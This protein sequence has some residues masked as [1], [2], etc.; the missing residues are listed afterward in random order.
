MTAWTRALA[1]AALLLAIALVGRGSP[2]RAFDADEDKLIKEAQKDVLELTKA[3][4]SGK[5]GKDI[6]ARMKKKYEDLN[7]IMQIYKPSTKKGLGIGPKGPGDSIETKIINLGK[8]APSAAILAKQ[9]ND[10]IKMV[11]I[12]LAMVE[13][14]LQYTPTKD[15][16]SKGAKEWKQHTADMK[17]GSKELLEAIK[18]GDPKKVKAAAN[19]L[20]SS[21]NNCHTDFRDPPS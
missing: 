3:I 13:V 10:L 7:T 16:G 14:T 18:S 19:N 1:L 21:C 20:N 8:R 11:Y 5:D 4:E 15:K 12:N 2:A 9:K 17:K 6:V